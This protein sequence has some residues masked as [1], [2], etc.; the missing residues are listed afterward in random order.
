[1]KKKLDFKKKLTS[2]Q[3][4]DIKSHYESEEISFPLPDKK[5]VG[6]RFMHTGLAK[7]HKMYNL[8]PSTTGKISA[9][10]FYKYKP[11]AIKLQGKIP[12][13][14]SCCEKCQ[15]FENTLEQ[16][17]KYM[18]G[19]PRDV[20]DCVDAS[21]C[22]YDGFFPQLTCILHTCEHCG[23][24]RFKQ[25]I[26]R[27]NA[28]RMKDTRKRFMVKV[29]VTK[30]KVTDGVKQSYLHWNHE[31]LNYKG[32]VTLYCEQLEDMAEHTFMATW[33]Y[34]Q[35]K[36]VKQNLVESD[37]LIVNDFAQNYLCEH[38]NEPQGLHWL[39]QQVTI[40]PSVAIYPCKQQGCNKL[41]KHEVVHLSDDLS[42]M[43]T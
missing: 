34:C 32:L 35:Y 25:K 11:K 36:K 38:Q 20:G 13:R 23:V 19:V 22:H 14:Q 1:M 9:S 12:F 29:W 24:E 8:L 17:S 18:Q 26:E 4:D 3:I 39:H 41:V 5:Y 31:R 6:K 30:T 43:H 16:I 10:T 27:L 21:L 28:L 40:H 37:V 15:N 7:A 42:M 2:A 33:N